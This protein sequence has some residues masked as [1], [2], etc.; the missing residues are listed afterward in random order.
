MMISIQCA[1]MPYN[2]TESLNIQ[3]RK[4][5]ADLDLSKPV[6]SSSP[7][8]AEA[9]QM[10]DAGLQEPG[11]GGVQPASREQEP[12]RLRPGCLPRCCLL[13]VDERLRGGRPG[14]TAARGGGLPAWARG[15]ERLLSAAGRGRRQGH[16]G[17][18]P[19]GGGLA[20][21]GEDQEKP[22]RRRGGAAAG[23]EGEPGGR[24]PDV[25]RGRGAESDSRGGLLVL[26]RVGK[27]RQLGREK[28]IGLSLETCSRQ[29]LAHNRG[30]IENIVAPYRERERVLLLKKEKTHNR[31][32]YRKTTLF[33]GCLVLFDLGR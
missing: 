1:P 28:A 26:A 4:I 3:N 8:C 16:G 23:R 7:R 5:E 24:A 31:E 14:G 12:G 30:T 2:M 6:G 25:G 19:A 13:D 22:R 18:Q 17:G 32:Y 11:A 33:F 21:W 29:Y 15:A 10:T 27:G 9:A 20:A